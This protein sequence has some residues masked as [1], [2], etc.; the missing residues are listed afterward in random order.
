MKPAFWI[1]KSNR[2]GSVLARN[3]G[4]FNRTAVDNIKTYKREGD[5]TRR[6]MRMT[7]G[8]FTAYAVYPGDT[9]DCCGRITRPNGTTA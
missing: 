6:L 4:M 3:G 8:A 9:L 1:I 2:F 7:S 5:A